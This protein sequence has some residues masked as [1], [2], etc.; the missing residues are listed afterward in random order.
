MKIAIATGPFIPPPPGP[1]GAVERLTLDLARRFAA[2]GH[3]VTLLSRRHGGAP[4]LESVEGVC[5]VRLR[6]SRSTKNVYVNI[7]KDLPYSLAAA[8]ALPEADIWVLNAFWLPWLAVRR[9]RQGGARI[10]VAAHRYPKGQY[11]LY[12]GVDRI[13]AVSQ[14]VARAIVAQAPW[15]K[16]LVNVIP[17]PIDTDAFTPV[18]RHFGARPRFL[19][20]GRIHPEKGLELLIAAFARIAP[21]IPGATLTIMGAWQAKQGGG[22][23]AYLERLRVLAGSAPVS[24]RDPVFERRSFALALQSSDIFVYPSIAEQGEAFG[25]A[26]LEAMAT[27]AVAVVSALDC[28]RDFLTDGA[29]GLVFNHRSPTAVEE[30]AALLS[31]IAADPATLERLSAAGAAKAREFDCERVSEY[32]LADYAALLAR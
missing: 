8:R 9:R 11:K 1:A 30:L 5:H 2:R 4:S 14:A 22:G 17:N 6:G 10:V 25:V 32:H 29:T 21:G 13:T 18:E 24:F 20:A 23:A 3:E 26:P 19:Y 7:L 16:D 28:F 12:R 31:R 15:S 27:G